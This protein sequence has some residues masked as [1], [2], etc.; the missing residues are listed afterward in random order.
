MDG[1]TFAGLERE[2]V[3]RSAVLGKEVEVLKMATSLTISTEQQPV[4]SRTLAVTPAALQKQP[5]VLLTASIALGGLFTLCGTAFT[6][7]SALA[8][9]RL[10][11]PTTC[12]FHHLHTTSRR[13]ARKNWTKP[14]RIVRFRSG[15]SLRLFGRYFAGTKGDAIII[16]HGFTACQEELMEVAARLQALGHSVLLFDFRNHGRSA[17]SKRG[18]SIG[19]HE[20]QDVCAAVQ[21][22][23]RRK[24]VDPHRIGV[25]GLSMGAATALFAAAECDDIRAVVADSPYASLH[26]TFYY[27]FR[28]F[29]SGMGANLVATPLLRFSEMFSGINAKKIRPIDIVSKIA[30]RPIMFIHGLADEVIRSADSIQMYDSYAGPKEQWLVDGAHHVEA[31]MLYPEEYLQRVDKFFNNYLTVVSAPTITPCAKNVM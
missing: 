2:P 16:C 10:T 4:L 25:I 29:Y 28:S 21:Y 14:P 23:K 19:Y 17:A 12:M 8:A 9:Y 27:G 13:N 24:G 20:R 31:G 18:S 30:P 15:D 6:A 22:L 3:T 7:L 5:R 11:H 26:D 1:I